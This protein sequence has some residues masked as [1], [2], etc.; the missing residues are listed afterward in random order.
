MIHWLMLA[1]VIVPLS[2]AV[3][4]RINALLLA[5]MLLWLVAHEITGYVDLKLVM[6]TR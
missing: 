6:A 4:F 2:L 5:V 1:E 3:F